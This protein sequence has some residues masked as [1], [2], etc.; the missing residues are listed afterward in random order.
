MG[1]RGAEGRIESFDVA[2]LED[3]VALSGE[4]GEL[5]GGLRCVGDGLLDE[6]MLAALEQKFP[7][8]VVGDGRRANRGRIDQFGELL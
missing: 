6:E 7:N 3:A 8:F 1:Q 5:A 4:F 2:D